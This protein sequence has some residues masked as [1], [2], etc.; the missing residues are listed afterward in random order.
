MLSPT[1]WGEIWA[2]L[3]GIGVDVRGMGEGDGAR[4]AVGTGVS[5]GALVAE[6]AGRVGVAV[7]MGV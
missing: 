7:S 2:G 6:G 3:G 4:V 5:P 1:S